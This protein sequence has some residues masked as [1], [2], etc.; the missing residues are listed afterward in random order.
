[1]PLKT[2]E[3][4]RF[5]DY[6]IDRLR[7]VIQ[8]QEQPI[9]VS[10]KSFDLLLY[11]IDHRDRVVSKDELLEQLWPEQ[12]VEE[13]NLTQ[14]IF[15]L[16]KALSKHEGDQKIIQTLP[17]RGYR[18]TAPLA[19]S[20]E[21][22]EEMVL[23]ATESIT[24]I[25][26]EEEVDDPVTS[27]SLVEVSSLAPSV[28]RRGLFLLISVALL[29][30]LAVGGWFGWQR[31]LDRSGGAPVQIVL[32]PLEGTTGDAILD[33]SLTQALRMDLAQ[34]PY[35][36][37]VPSSTVRATLTQ[38]MHKPDDKMTSAMAR[39]V[40]ERTN[41]Q[42]VLSGTIAK[43]G[44]HFL[45][46]EEATNCLDG[47]V[48]GQAKYEAKTA[49]DLPR[50]IDKISASL[51]QKLGESRR[52][53]ARFNMPLF[54]Q[55][56]P[57]LEALKAFTQGTQLI[58]EGKFPEAIGLLQTAVK[59]DP[60]FAAAY[61]NLAAA[62]ASAGDDLH[63]RDAIAKAYS[64]KDTAGRSTQFGIETM[65][66]SEYTGDMYELVRHFQSWVDLYPNSSQAWSGLA[67]AQRDLSM[68]AEALASQKRTVELLPHSQGM[69]ANLAMDQ[70]RAG[71]LQ[72]ARATC[73]RAIHDN[74]DGDGLRI[75]YLHLAYLLHDA[76]LLQAQREWF[77]AHPQASGLLRVEAQIAMSEGRFNDVHK[78]L[79]RIRDLH[80]QQGL[81]G[82]D[83][84]QAKFGAVDLM[85]IGDVEAGKSIFQQSPVDIE[86]GQEVLG[87]V[88]AGDISAAQ[89]GLRANEVK[90]PQA[91]MWKL[92]WGPRINAAIAMA[93]HRPAEAAAL[94]EVTRPFDKSGRFLPWL[95]GNAY[96]AAG[97]P[98]L[99]EKEYRSMINHPE[100]DPTS[101]CI[102]LSWLGLARSLR[103]EGNRS[104]AIDAY[105]HFLGLW[106]HADSDAAPL[107]QAK[108][109]LSSI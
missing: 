71:D 4:V 96:L 103:A 20:D 81:S 5:Y 13:S 52:S 16:R 40:C 58:R 82:A 77:A 32:I 33:L 37:V 109:E 89:A 92:F 56:T 84:E 21:P 90:Y 87:L 1:M 83:D 101:P 97:Q 95:R 25:T 41:S 86:D 60:K 80:H 72:G 53:L 93:Q 98:A 104:G 66:D 38:M 10:R 107:K 69:L 62:Y 19:E 30:A 85:Q 91:T 64:L 45:I 3:L 31:W 39:E 18:F 88:Y 106:V 15:L 65:Y 8:W 34:S 23:S 6:S 51:R 57:S 79:E 49:E 74:L 50:A 99:A 73:E 36:T 55:N 42:G 48:L 11:L 35:V 70:M 24:R 43:L 54:Q 59:D 61:Y 7:W 28:R 2:I 68:D 14:H 75:R 46:T 27:T 17:G 9:A 78:L 63:V 29:A 47:A 76:P 12:F 105:Q 26:V 94:L 67:N 102:P 44:Q 22:A 100:F 108:L